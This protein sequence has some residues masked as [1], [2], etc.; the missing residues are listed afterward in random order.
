MLATRV[1]RL[2]STFIVILVDVWGV[3]PF[4][5]STAIQSGASSDQ[6][7]WAGVVIF[8]AVLAA[9]LGKLVFMVKLSK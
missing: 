2:A 9:W 5:I 6:A 7:L 4:T 1:L 3:F 8:I